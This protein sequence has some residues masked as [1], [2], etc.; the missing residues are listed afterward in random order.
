MQIK[1]GVIVVLV[2]LALGIYSGTVI[3]YRAT[4][5]QLEKENLSLKDANKSLTTQL[6]IEKTNVVK[7]KSSI[8][9]VNVEIDKLSI[10]NADIKNELEKWQRGEVTVSNPNEKINSLL[11]SKLYLDRACQNGLIINQLLNEVKYEDL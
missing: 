8:E 6:A 5:G 4:I 9:K 10:R 11:D 7:L 2:V 3:H 1:L